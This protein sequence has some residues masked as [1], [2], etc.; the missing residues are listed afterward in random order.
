MTDGLAITLRDHAAITTV[1]ECDMI[2][3]RGGWKNPD[4]PTTQVC[5]ARRT[6]HGFESGGDGFRVQQELCEG[7]THTRMVKDPAVVKALEAL[8]NGVRREVGYALIEA[9]SNID[10]AACFAY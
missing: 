6:W 10:K 7:R 8:R 3:E 9:S 2:K 4:R 5:G 1:R